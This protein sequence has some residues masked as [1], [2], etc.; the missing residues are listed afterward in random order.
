VSPV[1]Y[2]LDFYI[3]E[4]DILH[5]HRR[6]YFKSY[7]TQ[8]HYVTFIGLKLCFVDLTVLYEA[9]SFGLFRFCNHAQ[10]YRASNLCSPPDVRGPSF[11]PMH[12][13]NSK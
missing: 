2:E 10:E 9:L 4:D 5:S 13:Q 11:T 8:S 7:I 6:G 1:R 12:L 3:T